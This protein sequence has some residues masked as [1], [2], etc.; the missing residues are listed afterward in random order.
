MFQSFD[1]DN[2]GDITITELMTILKVIHPKTNQKKLRLYVLSQGWDNVKLDVFFELLQSVDEYV[3]GGAE[4]SVS[5]A[6]VRV[7]KVNQ[8]TPSAGAI[9]STSSGGE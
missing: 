3:R 9:S 6:D 8:A 7:V 5:T 1:K 4:S 2:S